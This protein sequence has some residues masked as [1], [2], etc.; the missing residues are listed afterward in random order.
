MDVL[1]KYNVTIQRLIGV[2]ILPRLRQQLFKKIA[3][4]R[5]FDGINIQLQQ[6][7]GVSY[8]SLKYIYSY[9]MDPD[10]ANGNARVHCYVQ[11]RELLLRLVHDNEDKTVVNNHS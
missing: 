2:S 9:H 1:A 10:E 6:K 3:K 8:K 7:F 5:F 4:G 11:T